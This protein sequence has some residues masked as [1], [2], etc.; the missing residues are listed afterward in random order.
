MNMT[1]QVQAKFATARSSYAPVRTNLLQRKC[2]CGGAPGPDGEC[3]ECRAKR[4]QRRATSHAGPATVPP[5]VNEV[6]HSP[7]QPLDT[8]TRAF[9]EPRFGYDFSRVRVHADAK[10]AESARAVDAQAYAVGRDV[11]FGAGQYAPGTYTGKGLLAHELTHVVQQRGL[12]IWDESLTIGNANNAH[13]QEASQAADSLIYQHLGTPR[14]M[15]VVRRAFSPMIMRSQLLPFTGTWKICERLRKARDFR[16]SQGGIRV[17]ASAVYE[18]GGA[19]SPECSSA[20]YHMTLNQKGL[21]FDSEMAPANFP[22][23]PRDD[24]SHA[25]GQNC[26]TMTIISPSGRITRFRTAA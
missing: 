2:A 15:P 24:L 23:V 9:M 26:Q 8:A 12:D 3:A 20:D 13:E 18:K 11:V 25:F 1:A 6:L 14:T 22:R 7:G 4:L 16:V 19:P 21:L 17:T 10:A 5:I